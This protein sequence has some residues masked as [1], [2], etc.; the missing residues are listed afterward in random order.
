MT[1]TIEIIQSR[2]RTPSKRKCISCGTNHIKPG[3]RYCTKECRQ[4]IDWV[5]SLSKGLLRTFNTRYAAFSFSTTHVVLDVLPVC[6]DEISRF[7]TT[8]TI[9]SKPAN[10]LKFLVLQYGEEWH[11]LVDNNNSKSY[12]TFLILRKNCQKSTSLESIK[13][14]R[15]IRPRLSKHEN[16]SLKILN[17]DREALF[18]DC[19]VVRIESAYRKMAK[20]Y[21]PD[22]GGD[23]EKF[24]E[25]AEAR[26]QMV[27]WTENPQYTS[28]KALEGCWSYD[29]FT[30]KWTPPL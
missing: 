14:E 13:P 2:A 17:L 22:V 19:S 23:N 12:A 3:R 15:N 8:R 25:L 24:K 28:R 6:S 21:H 1:H 4:Q 16:A 18:A 9:G 26:R 5:L 30:G 27:L 20:V 11:D 7:V 10:D 29:G